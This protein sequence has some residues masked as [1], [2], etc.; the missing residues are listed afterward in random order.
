MWHCAHESI[1]LIPSEMNCP[2]GQVRAL[3]TWDI[4]ISATICNGSQIRLPSLPST[5]FTREVKV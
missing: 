2:L 4:Q 5:G 1:P 3:A